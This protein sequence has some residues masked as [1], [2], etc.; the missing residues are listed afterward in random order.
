MPIIHTFAIPWSMISFIGLVTE[1]NFQGLLF[2]LLYNLKLY[3]MIVFWTGTRYKQLNSNLFYILFKTCMINF[4]LFNAKT[5]VLN[6][7]S[8]TACQAY[9]N[10]CTVKVVIFYP[11]YPLSVIKEQKTLTIRLLKPTTALVYATQFCCAFILQYRKPLSK[12]DF[13]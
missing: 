8:L 3:K 4:I 7:I 11:P 1:P 13:L 12:H 2:P 5:F 9:Q 6:V 10:Y